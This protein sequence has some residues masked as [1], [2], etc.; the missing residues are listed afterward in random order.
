M[1]IKVV[2]LTGDAK[3]A[4]EAVADQLR[5]IQVYSELLPEQKT[6]FIAEQVKRAE[7]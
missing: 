3:S 1:N 6:A 4:A 7:R 2:L 5:V